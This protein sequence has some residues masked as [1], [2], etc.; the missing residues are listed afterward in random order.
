[1]TL[2]GVFLMAVIFFAYQLFYMRQLQIEVEHKAIVARVLEPMKSQEM[3]TRQ[4]LRCEILFKESL[5]KLFHCVCIFIT[6]YRGIRLRDYD[7]YT[8]GQR[9]IFFCLQ[10]GKAIPI[11]RLNDDYCDCEE[12]GSDEPETNA[13]TNGV[14]FCSMIPQNRFAHLIIHICLYIFIKYFCHS[15]SLTH[16]HTYTPYFFFTQTGI[17]GAVDVIFQFLVTE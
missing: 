16:T 13:C 4:I 7:L 2:M 17:Q 15:L 1:M 3:E 12:D 10:S 9:N 8:I 11:E 14:F 5:G 6:W